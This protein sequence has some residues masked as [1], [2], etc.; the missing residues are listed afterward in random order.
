MC[1]SVFD[2]S[3]THLKLSAFS[4]FPSFKTEMGSKHTS[5]LPHVL[6]PTPHTMAMGLDGANHILC[7]ITCLD[8][9]YSNSEIVV[10]SMLL[11]TGLFWLIAVRY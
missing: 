8:K 11:R 9:K 5:T 10:G 2:C 1:V 4:Y 3:Q 6:N 7:F